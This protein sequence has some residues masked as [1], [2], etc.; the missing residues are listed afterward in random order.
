[1]AKTFSLFPLLLF[2]LILTTSCRQSDESYRL[3]GNEILQKLVEETEQIETLEELIHSCPHLKMLFDELVAVIIKLKSW[4]IKHGAY[5]S[6]NE[7]PEDHALRLKLCQELNRLFRIPGGRELIEKSQ[8][9]ALEHLD[10]FE[11]KQARKQKSNGCLHSRSS[12]QHRLL[13]KNCSKC[14]FFAVT[15]LESVSSSTWIGTQVMNPCFSQ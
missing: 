1:M 7:D 12:T 9:K 11:K 8:E 4:Q 5:E 3:Q 10:A 6:P 14:S 15:N 13:A 2:L